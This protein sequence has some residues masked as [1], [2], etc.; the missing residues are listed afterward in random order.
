M[1]QNTRTLNIVFFNISRDK[2]LGTLHGI[3]A[4]TN[5]PRHTSNPR[6]VRD[7]LCVGK[8]IMGKP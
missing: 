1:C 8:F 6:R 5:Y 3:T 7:D 2:S 4:G